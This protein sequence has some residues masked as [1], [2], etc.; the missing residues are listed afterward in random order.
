LFQREKI[1]GSNCKLKPK[2]RK[3]RLSRKQEKKKSVFEEL[4]TSVLILLGRRR[5]AKTRMT[6]GNG[7][8]IHN[9]IKAREASILH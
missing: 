5:N 7:R 1:S 4:K 3:N 6:A 9:K 2:N 8:A